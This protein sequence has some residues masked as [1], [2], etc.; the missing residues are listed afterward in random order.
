MTTFS[1]GST[2]DDVV[3]RI[4]ERRAA[5]F[6]GAGVALGCGGPSG[7][8][9]LDRAKDHFGDAATERFLDYM[10]DVIGL[11]NA[12]RREVEIWVKEEGVPAVSA[13]A[14]QKYLFSLPWQ[15]LLTTNYD[16]L[17]ESVGVTL[18]GSRTIVPVA[19]PESEPKISISRQDLLYCFK[20]MGTVKY[21]FPI[22]GWMVLRTPDMSLGVERRKRFFEV[23]RELALSG[24]L[25]YLGYSFEDGLVLQLLEEMRFMLKE[26]SWKGYAVMPDKPRDEVLRA[27]HSLGVEWVQGDLAGLLAAAQRTFGGTPDS[28]APAPPKLTINRVQIEVDRATVSNVVNRYSILEDSMLAQ[29]RSGLSQRAFVLDGEGSFYPYSMKWDYPRKARTVW[30]APK[31]PQRLPLSLPEFTQRLQN[32][33]SSDNIVAALI[34]GAGS[35]K[36]VAAR[37]LAY[38]WYHSGN[39]V[40][41]VEPGTLVL[42]F[43]ALEGLLDEVWGK[44]AT[45]AAARAGPGGVRN[46]R[47]LVVADD[48]AGQLDGLIALKNRL[49]GIA[50]PVDIL[51]VARK[52]E[53]PPESLK[54]S[55]VDMVMELD[56]TVGEGEW[57]D[58]EKHF[59]RIGLLE[60]K[61][62]WERNLRDKAINSSFFALLYTSVRGLSVPLSEAVS[63]EFAKLDANAKKIYALVS[64]IQTFTLRPWTSLTARSAG[65]A[66]DILDAE[67]RRALGGVVSY[68][69]GQI[70]LGVAN[71]VQADIIAGLAFKNP[72]DRYAVLRSIVE[73]VQADTLEEVDLMH[74]LLTIRPRFARVSQGFEPGQRVGLLE[75]AVK[76]VPS[77]PLYIH[78]A[79]AQMDARKFDDSRSSLNSAKSAN[80]RSFH[81]PDFHVYDNEGRLE[82]RMAEE[83]VEKGD[84][85]G[86]R[87]HLRMAEGHFSDAIELSG[88]PSVAPHSYQGLGKT[89][90]TMAELA[91]TDGERWTLLLSAMYWLVYAENALG[92]WGN[93]E[94]SEYKQK[95]LSMLRQE[96][97]NAAKL[98][99]ISNTVGKANGYA[100][101][102]MQEMLVNSPGTAFDLVEKGLAIDKTNL[103]LIRQHVKLVKA[104][105]PRDLAARRRA[106]ADYEAVAARKFDVT[107]T[108]EL[109][110]QKYFDGDMNGGNR[111]FAAL[112]DRARDYPGFLTPEEENRWKDPT[113]APK[114]FRGT[115]L[116]VPSDQRSW[117]KI[118][119]PGF[120]RPLLVRKRE[121]Q[122]SYP[123]GQERVSFEIIFNMAGPQASRVRAITR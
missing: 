98:E 123:Q 7:R 29:P 110:M 9:L 15:A 70:A 61:D 19:D 102:A 50:K 116:E 77:R 35:G 3:A 37:R 85:E 44:Y 51:V 11:D 60:R 75:L 6:F 115:L 119:S 5:L 104:L 22:G 4:V 48:G 41:F 16:E 96:N 93:K 32:T 52:S 122:W 89:Y 78:L 114:M 74:A 47:F 65:V 113:G 94:V 18:D 53:A 27:M 13:N 2:L 43:N 26:F 17:P 21:N 42:D 63:N 54:S 90:E 92:E 97:L 111:L 67:M 101:M 69:E 107:L 105:S 39:P 82:L 25:V 20:L 31:S 117:G 68:R 73:N 108:F 58:F 106:L 59:A 49:R 84:I 14:E 57:D 100:F 23:F 24:H 79:M 109:A 120:P 88:G 121:L 64:F 86:A 62:V 45:T 99:Q 34:G 83:L 10:A 46:P 38:D 112:G 28:G 103:W 36:T 80:V 95:V 55:Q 91:P 72:A 12:N 1:R 81:E 8:E 87:E 66:R 40:V 118:E 56:D 30:T 76:K 33:N 71:R